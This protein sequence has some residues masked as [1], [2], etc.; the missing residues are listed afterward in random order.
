MRI[1]LCAAGLL[2]ATATPALATGGFECRPLSAS[3]P[4]LHL[5]IGH[6][7]SAR[8]FAVTLS[9]GGKS[10]STTGERPALVLGQSWIDERYLWLDLV[11][12]N[13]QRFEAKLR[14]TF[15][16][17]LRGR[18][19]IGTLTRNGRTWRVRCVEA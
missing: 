2:L 16:P 9:E 10:W 1:A 7:I 8:P 12:P 5:G 13:V 18:P 17:R 19:A 11:D 14:A 15:Q 6:V 3:G 4:V